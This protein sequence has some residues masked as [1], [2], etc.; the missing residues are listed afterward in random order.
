VTVGGVDLAECGREEWRR[1]LAWVPQRPTIFRGTVA[2]NIG[3]GSPDASSERLAA[4]ALLA[5]ADAFVRDLPARYDTV[6]GD[7]GRVLSTGERRRIAL[8][9]AI[10]RDAPLLILDEP[11]A[12]LDPVAAELVGAA[13]EELRP[14]RTVLVIA[15][16]PELAAQADRVVVLA[17]EPAVRSV[18]A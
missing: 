17:G 9:R 18:A 10:L 4:A 7:G 1:R 2:E 14:M 13:L 3:L 12:D 8:A 15:H 16:R 11:T 6:I 5:G